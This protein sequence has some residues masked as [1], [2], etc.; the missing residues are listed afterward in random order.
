[1][2]REGV[3]EICIQQT[4]DFERCLSVLNLPEYEAKNTR[5]A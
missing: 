1:M 2:N 5:L 4:E 3:F